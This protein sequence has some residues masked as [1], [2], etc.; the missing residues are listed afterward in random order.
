MTSDCAHCVAIFPFSQGFLRR[1]GDRSSS[2]YFE[3]FCS[4]SL[5]WLQFYRNLLRV[6]V[7]CFLSMMIESY[8]EYIEKI[9]L[10]LLAGSS[11]PQDVV[12]RYFLV[13]DS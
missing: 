3:I 12:L 5:S 7:S 10:D 2:V 4:F 9:F 13:P 11:P 1:P 6:L 8:D